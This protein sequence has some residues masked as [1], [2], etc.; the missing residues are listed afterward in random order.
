[1]KCIACQQH[2]TGP[3][4]QIDRAKYHASCIKCEKCAHPLPNGH[5]KVAGLPYCP[6]CATA[7]KEARGQKTTEYIK[8]STITYS[9]GDSAA[10]STSVAAGIRYNQVSVTGARVEQRTAV[11]T[12]GGSN[13]LSTRS[14]LDAP[15]IAILFP[16]IQHSRGDD[17]SHSLPLRS[18][19]CRPATEAEARRWSSCRARWRI[20]LQQM[21]RTATSEWKCVRRTNGVLSGMRS[22]VLRADKKEATSESS[23][24]ARSPCKD[25][26]RVGSEN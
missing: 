17:R 2:I 19:L 8:G 15:P 3:I 21:W 20:M 23:T 5:V 6:G 24:I 10:S 7:A 22:E 12:I 26:R 25:G 1:V 18:S 14:Q 9:G 11:R 13:S 4:V 16:F